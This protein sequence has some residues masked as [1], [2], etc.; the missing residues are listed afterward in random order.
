[1]GK[2]D[3]THY[4]SLEKQVLLVLLVA[5]ITYQKMFLQLANIYGFSI[6]IKMIFLRLEK[7]TT[8]H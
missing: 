3:R 8:Y 5:L 2:E 4:S 7:R 1:M 6:R